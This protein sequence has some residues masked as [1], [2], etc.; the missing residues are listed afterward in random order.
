[1]GF[2]IRHEPRFARFIGRLPEPRLRVAHRMLTKD[3]KAQPG[4]LWL[5]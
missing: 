1:M 5:W 4:M 3:R 2:C